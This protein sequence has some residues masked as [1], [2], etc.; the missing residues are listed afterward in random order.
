MKKT[1]LF[2][3][4]AAIFALVAGLGFGAYS[5][6][7]PKDAEVTAETNNSAPRP[8]QQQVQPTAASSSQAPT[9]NGI[10]I[11]YPDAPQAPGTPEPAPTYSAQTITQPAPNPQLDRQD[12]QAVVKEAITLFSSRTSLTDDT[13]KKQLE[14][15]TTEELH[16]EL[17]AMPM[18]IFADKYP[19]AVKD[20]SINENIKEWGIDTPVRYSHYATAQIV[21]Q[22]SGTLEVQYRIA[23]IKM[24]QGWTITDLA[25][26]SYKIIPDSGEKK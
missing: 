21:T 4:L 7:N 19:A 8:A 12:A 13:Y 25:V 9:D 11:A 17:S 1:T 14:P 6:L 10:K 2:I 5:L 26:D 23:A 24:E 15:L 3:I 20:V 16:S 18:S 22:N